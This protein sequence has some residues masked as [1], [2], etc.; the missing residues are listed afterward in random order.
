MR[1]ASPRM[2]PMPLEAKPDWP[3]A[4][5][6]WQAF[7]NDE[8]PTDRV[9]M[10]LG[11]PRKV[12]PYPEPALP[13]D[14]ERFH[15]D[16]DGF[17]ARQLHRVFRMEY[18]AEAVP[19]ASSSLTGGYLGI[20]LGGRLRA[21][22]D[23]VIWSYPCIEDWNRVERIEVD[24]KSRWYRCVMDQLALLAEHRD[25][26]MIHIP[27]LHGVSDA[28]VSIRG[29]T[30]LALDL[31]DDPQRIAWACR[32]VV[33][34]WRDAYE[35]AY[36]FISGIHAGTPVWLCMWHLGRVETVQEDFADV[37]STEQYR[38]HFMEHDRAFCRGL[39]RAIF[40]LHNTMTRFQE[41]AL[42]MPEISCTQFRLPYDERRVPVRLSTHLPLYRRMHA[43]GVKT[44]YAFLDEDDM[45][46]AIMQGDPRHLF[47]LGGAKDADEASRLLDKACEWTQ[48][49]VRDL[50][51]RPGS[52]VREP[53]GLRPS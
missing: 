52:G 7:W 49:R 41:V 34:A 11:V 22:A 20:L 2:A 39:D 45:R 26:F 35:E 46:D 16:L 29:A 13:E 14:F 32:Q 51:L 47:L 15:T 12:N 30:N 1:E 44:Q 38:T 37:L 31:I 53:S 42:E 21:L 48:R 18:W 4:A 25:Q 23:G 33:D 40:H 6:R 24:R 43:Q 28:L 50:G 8:V 10:A 27:D 5:R 19:S 36:S 17:R 3:D 9:L